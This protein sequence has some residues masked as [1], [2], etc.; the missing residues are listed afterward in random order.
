MN[1]TVSKLAFILLMSTGL[2][3]FAQGITYLAKVELNKKY[4]CV[5]LKGKEVI[6]VAYDDMGF[7][8]NNLI[9]VNKGAKGIDFLK[10]GGKWGYC[11][12]RGVLVIALQ[13]E[14]AET[15]HEGLAAVQLNKKWG[16]IDTTGKIVIAPKYDRAR[17]FRDGLC[18]VA[19]GK[20]WGFID[21]E[22]KET[23]PF[24]YGEL[25]EYENGVT[26]AFVG[27]M[28]SNEDEETTGRYCLL[29]KKGERIIEPKYKMIWNF[30]DGLAKVEVPVADNEY[31]SKSGY[32][33]EKG[34]LIIPAKYDD[35]RDFSEGMAV[36]GIKSPGASESYLTEYVYGYINTKGEEVVKPQYSAASEF[37]NGCAVITKGKQKLMYALEID[38]RDN[39]I[40]N[41]EKLPISA[42]INKD[43]GYILNFDWRNMMAIDSNVFIASRPK[44]NGE[45]VIDNKGKT[46]IPFEYT[47]LRYIGNNLFKADGGR[48][49]GCEVKV[50]DINN[51]IL[52]QSKTFDISDGMNSQE[53]MIFRVN[54][55]NKFGCINTRGEIVIKA[56]YD[57][58][59]EFEALSL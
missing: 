57:M 11:N 30:H 25:W 19:R 52:I 7:W 54:G 22:G 21:K 33:N 1:V 56:K 45:G 5:D 55:T 44:Y 47:N 10:K 4:G 3:S 15:F 43:G 36:V 53:M 24:E 28:A 2:Q 51:K 23:V 18:A 12:T 58:I 6:P 48:C 40:V 42:L 38:T 20:K 26:R 9:P 31:D 50:I 59:S 32:I 17:I 46:I 16:F 8:G 49:T 34:E 27:T 39:S 13:F 14:K 41:Y 37:I 35:A 29:N